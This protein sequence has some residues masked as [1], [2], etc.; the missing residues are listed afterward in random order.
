VLDVKNGEAGRASD[1]GSGKG[2]CAT[3]RTAFNEE[4]G[5]K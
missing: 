5:A 4:T 3:L 2:M 1:S